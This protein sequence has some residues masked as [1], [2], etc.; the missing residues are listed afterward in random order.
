MI[1]RTKGT[2]LSSRDAP[3]APSLPP[4]FSWSWSSGQA[5][6]PQGPQETQAVFGHA[7]CLALQ[8]LNWVISMW[9]LA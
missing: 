5:G 2:L 6:P 1:T 7:S 8:T 4:M 9:N 3:P